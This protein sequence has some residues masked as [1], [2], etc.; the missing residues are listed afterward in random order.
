M[1]NN[2]NTEN[3]D[4]QF[5]REKIT[6][7]KKSRVKKVL[8][9]TAG[10]LVLAVLFGFLARFT[11]DAS[12]GVVARILGLAPTPTHQPYRIATDTPVPTKPS[13]PAP[14][15]TGAPSPTDGIAPTLTPTPTL[16]PVPTGEPDD[17]NEKNEALE[18]LLEVYKGL[19]EVAKA[20]SKFM[21]EVRLVTVENDWFGEP[22]ETSV[23]ISGIILG[24]NG[25]E[26]LLLVSAESI[27]KAD[28]IDAVIGGETVKRVGIKA[29]NDEYNLAVLTVSMNKLTDASKA[30][31]AYASFAGDEKPVPGTPL[32]AIGNPNGYLGSFELGMVTTTGDY[33]YVTDNRLEI[34]NTD[35][36]YRENGDGVFVDFD[37]KIVGI[38]THKFRE[39]NESNLMS[40]VSVSNMQSIIEDLANCKDRNYLGVIAKEAPESVLSGM[41]LKS[42]LY[43]TEVKAGSPAEKGGIKKG[44]IITAMGSKVLDTVETLND[45]L[46]GYKAGDLVSVKLARN[47]RA[48]TATVEIELTNQVK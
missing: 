40:M 8:L 27:D 4:Y 37:G 46:N 29:S 30:A 18:A 21:T 26:L 9:I 23:S 7:K 2:R 5:V 48:L 33:A 36:T 13:T 24:D 19:R 35:L 47:N 45:C 25:E 39:K 6:S 10:T 1:D 32:L 20:A 38:I 22:L 17:P 12:E 28:R 31:I 3:N 34:M 15:F 14:S 11:F 43:V 41:G 16:T 44:D 42:G